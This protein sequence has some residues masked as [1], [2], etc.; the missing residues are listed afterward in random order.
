MINCFL[1]QNDVEGTAHCCVWA[2]DGRRQRSI[3]GVTP[4]LRMKYVTLRLREKPVGVGLW[5]PE[6]HKRY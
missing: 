3:E 1:Q 6:C 4:V 2:G 5:V